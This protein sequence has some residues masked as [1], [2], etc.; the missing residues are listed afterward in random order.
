MKEGNGRASGRSSM[1]R[2]SEKLKWFYQYRASSRPD[3]F[4]AGVVAQQCTGVVSSKH[5]K[6]DILIVECWASKCI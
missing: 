2:H 5:G 4:P 6:N 1:Q 3:L